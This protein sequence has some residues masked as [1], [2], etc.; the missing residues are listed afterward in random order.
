MVFAV[1]F[2]RAMGKQRSRPKKSVRNIEEGVE[3]EVEVEELT[4]EAWQLRLA[5]RQK[6]VLYMAQYTKTAGP[7]PADRTISKR[8]WEQL[9]QAWRNVAW[10]PM[11]LTVVP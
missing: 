8:R 3:E 11:Y 7:D 9:C 4:E 10:V 5:K 1:A 2:V 6:Y